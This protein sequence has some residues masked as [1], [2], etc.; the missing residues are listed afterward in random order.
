[1]HIYI[2]FSGPVFIEFPIDTLYPYHVVEKE[3]A[4]KNAPKGIVGKIIS[5]YDNGREHIQACCLKKTL[6]DSRP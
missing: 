2:C 5:W 1:M 6:D 4:P 3:F